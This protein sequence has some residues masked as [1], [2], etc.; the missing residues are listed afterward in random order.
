[1]EDTL[2]FKVYYPLTYIIISLWALSHKVHWAGWDIP[3]TLCVMVRQLG[4]VLCD[5]VRLT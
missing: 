4:S 5:G 3:F 1:M 2:G